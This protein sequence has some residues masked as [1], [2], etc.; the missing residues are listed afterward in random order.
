M[1]SVPLTDYLPITDP[2]W[3]QILSEFERHFGRKPNRRTCLGSTCGSKPRWELRT[4]EEKFF[5]EKTLE[6]LA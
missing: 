2:R 5:V 1:R 6:L 4:P 3:N